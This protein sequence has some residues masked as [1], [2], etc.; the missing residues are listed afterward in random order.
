[1]VEI[2]TFNFKVQ[3]ATESFSNNLIEIKTTF[4]YGSAELLV[5]TEEEQETN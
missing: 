3:L 5:D 1:M 2:I 4:I